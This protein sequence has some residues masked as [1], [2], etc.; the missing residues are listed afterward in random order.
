MAVTAAQTRPSSAPPSW[1]LTRI[2]VAPAARR[3]STSITGRSEP[4]AELGG[5][6]AELRRVVPVLGGGRR[7][8]AGALRLVRPQG[9]LRGAVDDGDGRG[10]GG[11]APVRL[12]VEQVAQGSRDG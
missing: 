10:G 4:D 2:C 9:G 8:A 1:P 12:V 7:G 5:F 6:L 3:A 11:L